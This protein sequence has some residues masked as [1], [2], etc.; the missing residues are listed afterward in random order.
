M[1]L[2]KSH[3]IIQIACI[4]VLVITIASFFGRY[5]YLELTTHF[6]LQY[7]WFSAICGI[8]FYFFKNWKFIIPCLFCFALNGIYIFPYYFSDNHKLTDVPT[9]NFK[10]MLANVEGHNKSYDKLLESVK[11]ANPDVIVLQEITEEWWQNIQS[12]TSEYPNFKALP[13]QG[14]GGLVLLSRFPLEQVEILTLDESTHLAMSGKININGTILSILTL[15]PPTP[16][17]KH[18]FDYRNRQFAKAA[19]LI[20]S[21]PEPKLLIGDLNTSIWSPYFTELIENSGLQDV[22]KGKGI[23]PSWHSF[24]P[25]FMRIPIDHCL[26]S[27]TIEVENIELGNFTGSD[28][29]PLIVDL[30]LEKN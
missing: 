6:R 14:G 28:H 22:R 29:Y 5:P 16:M 25:I 12:I 2:K 8:G 1:S 9:I 7:L 10:L 20:K 24:L 15:H 27:E 23:Y 18:K 21:E 26:V 19:S 17:R 13:R 3:L 11:S 30:K 4:I